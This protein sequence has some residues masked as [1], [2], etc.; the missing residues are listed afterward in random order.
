MRR[1]TF[2][3]LA[4]ILS[5]CGTG[6]ETKVTVTDAGASSDAGLDTGGAPPLP[7]DPD[8]AF[9][10]GSLG[11]PAAVGTPS[12]AV[13]LSRV[14][15]TAR[16]FGIVAS[17]KDADAALV[18]ALDAGLGG[19]ATVLA[20][21]RE[22]PDVCAARVETRALSPSRVERVGRLAFVVPGTGDVTV[23]DDADGIV[24][25]FRDLPATADLPD[26]LRAA[27]S[28]S[29]DAAIPGVRS[30]VRKNE[31]LPDEAF[32]ATNLYS[33]TVVAKDGTAIPA[34]A[35]RARKVV[36]VV[37][38]R[39]ASA[40]A[41]IAAWLRILGKASLVGASVPTA[42]AES[43]WS[44]VGG[45]GLHVRTRDL[46]DPSGARW[47]DLVPAD[48]G[49]S[50][51]RDELVR[52]VDALAEP[53][54]IVAS[55]AARR[56]IAAVKSFAPYAGTREVTL[57][58][59]RAD[60]LVVH[61]TT[62]LFFPY[63]DVVGDVIDARL[64]EVL[65]LLPT[66]GEVPRAV[67]RDALRRFGEALH[68]GHNFVVDPFPASQ[69]SLPIVLEDAAGRAVVRRSGVDA[70]RPGD[71]IVSVGGVPMDAWLAREL[72]RTSAATDGYRF[73]LA[74][75]YFRSNDFAG[76][77][78]FELRSP[79][80]AVR[81]VT[82]SPSSNATA[83]AFGIEPT[84][85]ANGFLADLGAPKV[86]Y[87]SLSDRK[88]VDPSKDVEAAVAGNATAMILDMRGYPGSAAW[89]AMGRFL[90]ADAWSPWF[91]VPVRTGPDDLRVDES[92]NPVPA[93]AAGATWT[94]PLVWIVGPRTVS[95]A[96]T[97]S[98]TM[99]DAKRPTHVVGQTSAGTNGN[100][101]GVQLPSGFKFT[102]TGM[103][104]LHA[105]RSRYHGVGIVPDVPV[106]IDPVAYAAGRDP[107]LEAAIRSLAP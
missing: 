10:T 1:S 45:L 71:T 3:L 103:E 44:P 87:A 15:A 21:A 80:G 36:V 12:V 59:A 16:F 24:L 33:G 13:A 105:D 41:E 107:E 106:A 25:D 99:V 77:T 32:T 49:P 91:R 27:V 68:D 93:A 39:M 47:P 43:T 38:E 53:T 62:R 58:S 2:V 28:A 100:I 63:F 6:T 61:G 23:P 22:F 5:G 90:S 73:D 74:T 56:K 19:E 26:A 29:F 82:V 18:R 78:V 75:R 76:P 83:I 84:N 37:D 65:A 66:S 48:A 52:V 96:E 20:Y 88:G 72:P 60:L 102:F 50:S 57:A 8:D 40:T 14:H 69:G 89:G 31:G 42:L 4:S 30:R 70:L 101:T 54:P 95:A 55:E 86:Y 9:C 79:D 51:S 64:D 7:T 97:L 81:S 92:R 67:L 94:G 35:S 85:R 34:G 46:L 98:T 17:P 11:G 104:V